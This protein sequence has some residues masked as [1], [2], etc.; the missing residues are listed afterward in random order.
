MEEGG[1]RI[2]RP[3]NPF[4]VWSQQERKKLSVKMPGVE[5]CVKICVEICGETCVSVKMPGWGEVTLSG[6]P[7][8]F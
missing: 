4:M 5:T 1:A 2:R 3:L 7:T 8:D 6:S